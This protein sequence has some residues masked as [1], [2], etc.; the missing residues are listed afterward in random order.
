MQTRTYT[1]GEKE[2]A[3]PKPAINAID[4]MKAGFLPNLSPNSPNAEQPAIS[5]AKTEAAIELA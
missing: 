5:P 3:T 1:F 2:E 4:K